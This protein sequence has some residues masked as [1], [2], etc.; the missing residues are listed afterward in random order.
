MWAALPAS[1]GLGA[2]AQ[3]ASTMRMGRQIAKVLSLKN[4]QD[5]ANYKNANGLSMLRQLKDYMANS[6]LNK[7]NPELQKEV[8]TQQL[9]DSGMETL[10]V[11]TDM[12]LNQQG[13]YELLQG[14]Y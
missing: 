7:K 5:K 1:I 8:L 4:E 6:E 13:G 14:G 11:D 3:G 9:A 12:V 2:A 10:A